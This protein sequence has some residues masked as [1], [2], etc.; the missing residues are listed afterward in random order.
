MELFLLI[1]ILTNVI[2]KELKS[3]A[4]AGES[5]GMLSRGHPS[6]R[7]IPDPGWNY[8]MGFVSGNAF[9]LM[10]RPVVYRLSSVNSVR[11][12]YIPLHAEAAIKSI[13]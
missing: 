5:P 13:G 12:I 10:E 4:A 2:L 1:C 6:T 9:V 11:S 8:M 7:R 3:V